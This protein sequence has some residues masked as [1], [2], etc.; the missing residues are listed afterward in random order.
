M[1]KTIIL[2]HGAWHGGWCFDRVTGPLREQGYE[3]HAPDLPFSGQQDDF[4]AARALI[5]GHPGAIVLGHSY[6]GAVITAAC[7]GLDVSHLVYLCAF[8]GE[9]ADDTTP[10]ATTPALRNALRPADGRLSVDPQLGVEVFYQDCPA[11]AIAAAQLKLRSMVMGDLPAVEGVPAWQVI[12]STYV[13]CTEDNAIP[14]VDQ[15]ALA[16][17]CTHVVEW[18]VSHSPFFAAPQLMVDLL[19]ELAA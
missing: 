6:G 15:R 11:D 5:A 2:I 10:V 8:V 3:V 17:R 14:V 1:S 18:Q 19:A 12:P 13:V 16:R 7:Q 9:P 4:Q